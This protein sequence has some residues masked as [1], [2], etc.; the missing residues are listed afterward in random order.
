[1]LYLSKAPLRVSLFG[2]GTDFPEYYNFHK[3]AVLGFS[4]NKYIYSY[5]IEMHSSVKS[6][7]RI[8]YKNMEEVSKVSD[9]NHPTIKAI[10]LRKNY[11]NKSKWHFGTLADVPAG[12]GLGSSSSFT[13]SFL[14][15]LNNIEHKKISNLKIAEQANHIEREILNE[16]VGIQ[17]PYHSALGGINF[18]KFYK[19]KISVEKIKLT[20]E[21]INLLNDSMIMCYVGN[22]RKSSVIS[23][24]HIKSLN[25]NDNR[26]KL[27]QMYL[28]AVEA[29]NIISNFKG[30]DML[31]E[32]GNLLN[33]NWK[34]KRSL[35]K[36]ISD[37]KID[38]IINLGLKNG[39]YGAKLC[40]AGGGGFIFFLCN[41][42][43]KKT[44]LNKIQKK[45]HCM[46]IKISLSG[47]V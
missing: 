8:S 4:I 44:L 16:N 24:H 36:K 12:T 2:G 13:V 9:I 10:L 14:K 27:N 38:S 23:K 35:T 26:D 32:L 11:F 29:K 39:A 30:Q 6:K 20:N 22:S 28:S 45:Y 31:K 3:G 46:N 33:L 40:G 17:D 42:M 15:L 37:K 41:K 25:Y 43:N 47:V 5:A 19:N 7:F 21:K 34:F 18:I 1:M